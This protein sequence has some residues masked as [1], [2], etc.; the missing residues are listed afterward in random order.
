MT[1]E[2]GDGELVV[3]ELGYDGKV[4]RIKVGENYIYPKEK[5]SGK[6]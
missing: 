4:V 1:G 3:F 2:N 5:A 6:E